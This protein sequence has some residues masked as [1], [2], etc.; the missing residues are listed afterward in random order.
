ELAGEPPAASDVVSSGAA[1]EKM[2][3]WL[4]AQGADPNVVD[5]DSLLPAAPICR[6]VVC[7]ETGFMSSFAAEAIGEAARELGA[8][9]LAK[10]DKIDPSV[11]IELHAEVGFHVGQGQPIFTIHAAT[12][13]AASK[14]EQSLRSAFTV[15]NTSPTQVQLFEEATP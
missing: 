11:G 6:D 4:S 14:A 9:R 8:G 7:T 5:D 13:D 2:R 10:S 1:L 12:A 3:D 15:A